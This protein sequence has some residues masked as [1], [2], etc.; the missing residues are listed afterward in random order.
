MK[1]KELITQVGRGN[2]A[3]IVAT[4]TLALALIWSMVVVML[5]FITK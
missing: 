3:F 2:F 1:I 4:S 5:Y